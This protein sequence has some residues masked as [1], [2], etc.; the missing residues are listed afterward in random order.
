MEE[1][2]AGAEMIVLLFEAFVF[3]PTRR[4]P[5]DVAAAHRRQA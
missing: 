3:H 1:T 5:A 2:D 4:H